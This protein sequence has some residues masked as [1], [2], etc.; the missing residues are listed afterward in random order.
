[1]SVATLVQTNSAAK[2][3]FT[4]MTA[5]LELV[6]QHLPVLEKL[7]RKMNPRVKGRGWTMASPEDLLK[8][9]ATA[10][11]DIGA[12]VDQAKKYEAELTSRD[13]TV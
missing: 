4:T 9:V 13:W 7:I 5:Q 12:I 1:M 6:Q 11:N 2:R 10:R 8:M 3:R